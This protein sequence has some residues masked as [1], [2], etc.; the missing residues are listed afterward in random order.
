[1]EQRTHSGIESLRQTIYTYAFEAPTETLASWQDRRLWVRVPARIARSIVQYLLR[2]VPL[3]IE[4][5]NEVLSAVLDA[6]PLPLFAIVIGVVGG[7]LIPI[8]KLEAWVSRIQSGLWIS[9]AATLFF[10]MAL[11]LQLRTLLRW[12]FFKAGE[13]PKREIRRAVY[14]ATVELVVSAFCPCSK[15]LHHASWFD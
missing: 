11:H 3:L 6:A 7:A 10:A 4:S 1:M 5:F 9:F 2:D 12:A 15:V 8:S 13:T 14:G